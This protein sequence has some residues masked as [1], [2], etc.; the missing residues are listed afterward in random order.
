MEF[1]LFPFKR[2][3]WIAPNITFAHVI[4]SPHVT[5]PFANIAQIF[6]LLLNIEQIT[7]SVIKHHVLVSIMLHSVSSTIY[8]YEHRLSFLQLV[9]FLL[10]A[11]QWFDD[12]IFW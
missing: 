1:F 5:F 8:K 10:Y 4:D 6:Q 11:D 2:Q 7:W 9:D 12:S 3:T